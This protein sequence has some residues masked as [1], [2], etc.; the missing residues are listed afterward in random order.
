L[1]C[2]ASQIPAL[3]WQQL[4]KTED[5]KKKRPDVKSANH[6]I[7]RH[8]NEWRRLA[9]SEGSLKNLIFNPS[10]REFLE[11]YTLEHWIS[12][13]DMPRNAAVVQVE[14]RENHGDFHI[15]HNPLWV[16]VIFKVGYLI[17]MHWH[18]RGTG[19]QIRTLLSNLDDG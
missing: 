11:Q 17:L 15:L 18:P 5:L 9:D 14:C 10:R 7:E 3:R 13:R 4:R 1:F 2:D 16:Q 12:V 6:Y 8:V 19:L